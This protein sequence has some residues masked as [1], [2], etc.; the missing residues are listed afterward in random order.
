MTPEKYAAERRRFARVLGTDGE[1]GLPV[2]TTLEEPSRAGHDPA[3]ETDGEVPH[4]RRH[5]R[6]PTGSD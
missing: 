6:A 2:G 4:H 3:L 1:F 5:G